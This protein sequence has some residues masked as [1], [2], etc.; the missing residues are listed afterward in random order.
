MQRLRNNVTGIFPSQS[1]A[2]LDAAT[3]AAQQPAPLELRS[4][5][6]AEGHYE[7]SLYDA[8]TKRSTWIRLNELGQDFVVKAFNAADETVTVEQHGRTYTL[9]LK[10]AK[11]ATLGPSPQIRPSAILPTHAGTVDQGSGVSPLTMDELRRRDRARQFPSPREPG[12]PTR[13]VR[14]CRETKARIS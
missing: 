9:A 13:V 11:L 1:H 5:L 2:L 12:N 14:R 6:K 3:W 10:E 7:F 8:A 4:I